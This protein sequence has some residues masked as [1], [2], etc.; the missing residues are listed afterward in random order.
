MCFQFIQTETDDI[1]IVI[2]KLYNMMWTI[3]GQLTQAYLSLLPS[4]ILIQD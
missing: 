3:H 4:T 1:A 2:Y